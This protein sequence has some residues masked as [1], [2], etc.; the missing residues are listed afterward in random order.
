MSVKVHS[1]I[2]RDEDHNI[3]SSKMKYNIVIKG[4]D[5]IMGK[6]LPANKE[7]KFRLI[8]EEI[9]KN[10]RFDENE[11][12]IQHGTTTVKEHCIKVAH[13]AYFMSHRLHITVH[14]EELI[15]GAL[16]HDYFLYDWHEK[17]L[18]NSIH[19]FTHPGKALREAS[20]DFDLTNIEKDMI[21]SHMFPLTVK[22]PKYREGVLLC[23]AD[24]L[25]ALQ[26]TIGGH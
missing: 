9:R 25:C 16:L 6:K 12:Y 2:A 4:F 18:K 15:R 19:G 3:F 17:S 13:T 14:E 11:Q 10:S 1:F 20:K 26:E 5:K 8:L 24:K 22:P 7:E 21:Q 23:I